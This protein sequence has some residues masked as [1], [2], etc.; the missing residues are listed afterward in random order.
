MFDAH[1]FNIAFIMSFKKMIFITSIRFIEP[2]IL[3]QPLN[4]SPVFLLPPIANAR[5]A[6]KV[7][8]QV[9]TY[10]SPISK[11]SFII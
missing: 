6:I 8:T 1:I 5:G 11:N 3:H 9:M 4:M 7:S 10:L 2:Y